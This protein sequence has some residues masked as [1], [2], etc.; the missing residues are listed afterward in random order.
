MSLMYLK[1]AQTRRLGL[2]ITVLV[3]MVQITVDTGQEIVR[4]KKFM[5]VKE[6]SGN[7]IWSQGN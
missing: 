4:E 7:V 1:L 5:K 6:K 2:N 3:L